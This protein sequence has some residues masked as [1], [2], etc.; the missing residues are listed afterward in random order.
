MLFQLN[1]FEQLCINYTN[2]KLQ[3]L[4]NHTM[5]ILE[6]V[7]KPF[8]FYFDLLCSGDKTWYMQKPA[9]KGIDGDDCD[10]YDDW[11]WL[12]MIMMVMIGNDYDLTIYDM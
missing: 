10:D 2:E 5:F 9:T 12:A 7:R 3:Q 6:Q 8:C 4:F 1:S 11:Q